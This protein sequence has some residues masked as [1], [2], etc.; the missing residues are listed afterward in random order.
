MKSLLLLFQR[1][2]GTYLVLRLWEQC[3]LARAQADG[4]TF[5]PIKFRSVVE[6]DTGI[7]RQVE[8]PKRVKPWWN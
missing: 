4:T 6:K 8:M 7:R 5:A 1:G 3:E 2:I